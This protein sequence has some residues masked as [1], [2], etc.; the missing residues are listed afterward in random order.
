MEVVRKAHMVRFAL[1]R[2]NSLACSPA[3]FT[4]EIEAK[5]KEIKREKDLLYL[6]SNNVQ[7]ASI[8]LKKERE[9]GGL[10]VAEKEGH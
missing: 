10:S 7:A 4:K 8:A 6:L 2:Y 9:E 1:F 3:H 5:G